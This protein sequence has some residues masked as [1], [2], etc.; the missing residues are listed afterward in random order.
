MRGK[1]SK[2][3]RKLMAQFEMTF[4][5]RSPYQVLVDAQIIE[6]TEKFKMD[7]VGGLERTLSGKNRYVVASQ[8]ED[9][10]GYCRGIKGVPLVFVKRSVMVMEPMAANSVNAREGLIGKRKRDENDGD[11]VAEEGQEAKSITESD[12]RAGKKKKRKGPKGPN[13]LSVKK[14]KKATVGDQEEETRR[15]GRSDEN[16]SYP[17]AGER[18]VVTR[19]PAVEILDGPSNET[20]DREAKRKRKR[21]H[22]SRLPEGLA[23]AINSGNEGSE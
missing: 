6:D 23:A 21:K 15:E 16:L 9:V 12:E 19:V 4:G 17:D 7:L 2:Q 1:R 20:Q 22:K 10:R 8:D 11:A 5:F 3:Y 14:P 13:P 18:H